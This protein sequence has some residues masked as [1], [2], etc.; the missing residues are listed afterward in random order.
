[1]S[2]RRCRL[3]V[4]PGAQA[5]IRAILLYTRERWGVEQRRRYGIQLNRALRSLL[6]YP[7]RGRPRDELYSGCRSLPVE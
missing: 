2:A 4:Q 5:D 7:E 6:D 3:V 1:M